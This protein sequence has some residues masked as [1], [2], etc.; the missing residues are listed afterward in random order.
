MRGDDDDN[1][2][3][4]STILIS[5]PPPLQ[6]TPAM[7]AMPAR[8][9]KFIINWF[10]PIRATPGVLVS[11]SPDRIIIKKAQLTIFSLEAFI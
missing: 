9:D 6:V 1:D 7:P 10:D 8:L 3:S 4:D 11:I 5:S 2:L